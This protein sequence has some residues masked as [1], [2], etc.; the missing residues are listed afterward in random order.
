MPSAL[1]SR[2]AA[3]FSEDPA[4]R[5][6]NH[7]ADL[8]GRRQPI[9]RHAQFRGPHEQGPVSRR[10]LHGGL[11]TAREGRGA[12]PRGPRPNPHPAP[13]HPC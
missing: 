9:S 11:A 6:M 2:L 12:R 3:F 13:R 7:S 1:E 4:K 5:V 10:A 8:E